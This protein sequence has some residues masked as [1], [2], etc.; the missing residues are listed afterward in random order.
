MVTSLAKKNESP[1]ALSVVTQAINGHRGF[2]DEIRTCA[3]CAEENP[4]KK[5]SK[6]RQVHY[7]DRE[8]QRLHWFIHKKECN[9]NVEDINIKME[10]IKVSE[11]ASDCPEN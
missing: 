6:C 2:A 5:C 9:R 1:E 7:C 8:C 11:K 10:N 4:A 3:T